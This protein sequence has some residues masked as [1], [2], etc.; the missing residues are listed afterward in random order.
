VRCQLSVRCEVSARSR[1]RRT[2]FVAEFRPVALSWK[3]EGV[4]TYGD[5]VGVLLSDAL[6]LCFPLLELV[7]CE[8]HQQ[9]VQTGSP[10][11]AQSVAFLPSLNL[12]LMAAVYW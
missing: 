11:F 1:A 8:W 3:V 7:L 12:L 2:F 4:G 9:I 5:A 10:P 6:G